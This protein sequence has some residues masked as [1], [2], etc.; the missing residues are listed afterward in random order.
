[1][2]VRC[3]SRSLD[4]GF[5]GV[6]RLVDDEGIFGSREPPDTEFIWTC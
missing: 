3:V 5:D 1:M 4:G 2:D 6:V